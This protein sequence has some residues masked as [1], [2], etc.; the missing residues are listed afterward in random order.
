M[1]F[2]QISLDSSQEE[3]TMYIKFLQSIIDFSIEQE[4]LRQLEYSIRVKK[5]TVE[6]IEKEI[7]ETIKFE[8]DCKEDADIQ[9]SNLLLKKSKLQQKK[10]KSKVEAP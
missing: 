5:K 8:E 9:I 1:S 3:L 10:K 2:I 6:E 7:D 4:K